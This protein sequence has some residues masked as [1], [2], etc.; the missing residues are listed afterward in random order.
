MLK[1]IRHKEAQSACFSKL[2]YTLKPPGTKGGVTRVEVKVQGS[3]VAYTDK[4]DVEQETQKYTRKHFN[5]AAGTPFTDH[6]SGQHP[7]IYIRQMDQGHQCHDLQE[8][9]CVLGQPSQ[10]HSPLR[11]RLV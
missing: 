5:Q 1:K 11:S 6:G 3:V 7:R 4:H 9:W 8:T 10:S 2:S